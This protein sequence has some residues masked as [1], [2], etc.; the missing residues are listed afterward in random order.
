MTQKDVWQRGSK[1]PWD[2][3]AFSERM[4]SEH[5]SQ[6]HD[7]ASRRTTW[8]EQQVTWIHAEL[9]GGQ[10]AQILDLG[11]GPGLYAHRLTT[12]GHMVRGVDFGPASIAYAEQH[13]PDPARC[14]FVLGDLRKVDFGGPNEL[15]MMLFGEFNTFSPNDIATILS[16][17]RHSLANGG[18]L[19]CELQAAAAVEQVG[20]GDAETQV[21][22]SGLFSERPYTCQIENQWL[23]EQ[24]VTVQT[25]TVTRTESDQP[26]VYH[27]TAKAWLDD[28]II[29]LFE[30]AG[31]SK[32]RRCS[33]WPCDTEGLELWIAE[34]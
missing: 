5:L 30:T 33:A 11:C 28:E 18:R 15:V 12:L 16:K 7:M 4:L 21:C 27:S 29:A 25:F 17:A 22:E 10:P 1:I 34:V 19:I 3:P 26:Q 2:D 6:E 24:R 9:L 13:N 8:I 20:H 31:L 23:P 14:V 32:A